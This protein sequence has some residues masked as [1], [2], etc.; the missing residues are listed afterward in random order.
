MVFSVDY[1]WLLVICTLALSLN[2][3]AEDSYAFAAEPPLQTALQYA[4]PQW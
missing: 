3:P 2:T 1:T 4:L